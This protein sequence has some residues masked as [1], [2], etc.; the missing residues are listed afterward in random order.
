M[1]SLRSLSK[2]PVRYA[3]VTVRSSLSKIAGSKISSKEECFDFI[4]GY[5]PSFKLRMNRAGNVAK[6]CFD[7]ADAIA[8]GLTYYVKE[9]LGV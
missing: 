8:V 3:V 4:C 2:D 1:A 5:F 7:E 9:I 6:E